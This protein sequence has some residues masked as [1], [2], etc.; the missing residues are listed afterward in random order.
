MCG[1]VAIF[2]PGG[3]VELFDRTLLQKMTDVIAHRGPDAQGHH[4]ERHVALGHRRLS[5]ID[6]KSGQQPLFNE[7]GSVCVVFN[8]EIYNYRELVTEL[9]AL[10]HVFGTR[11]DTEVIVHGWEQWGSDCVSRFR[12]MFAFVVWD[13]N[14]R[15]LFAAR[16]RLGV[17]PLIYAITN[18]RK[19]VIASEIKAIKL[20]PGVDL[21]LDE[22]AVEDFLALSYIPDPKSIFNGIKKLPPA[23]W[24]TWEVG[25]K[26]PVIR[27]YWQVVFEPDHRYNLER[28]SEEFEHLITESVRIRMVSEVPIGAFLSG[29]VDSSIVVDRMS[30]LSNTAVKTCTIGFD[31]KSVDESAHALLVANQYHTEHFQEICT[32]EARNALGDVLTMF[33]EPFADSSALPTY[34]VSSIARKRVTVALS[35]DG[36]DETF[37]GYRRH[38]MHLAEERIRSAIP[39][40]IRS[41]LFGWMGR[42]YPKADWAPQ[43]FRAK[44]T[45]QGLA[46]DSVQ[47]YFES[48]SRIRSDERQELY[49]PGFKSRLNGYTALEVFRGHS[50]SFAGED[51]LS[52][53]QHLDYET[54]LPGDINTKVDRASM[55]NSLEVREPFMDHHLVEWA[56]RLPSQ[57]K[58]HGGQGKYLVKNAFSKR[59]PHSILF[60]PKQGFVVPLKHWM[61]ESL[62]QQLEPALLAS[63]SKLRYFLAPEKIRATLASHRSG[64]TDDASKL[65]SI[66]VLSRF[67][68]ELR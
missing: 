16:D 47:S 40:A 62:G 22:T 61:K 24:M 44:T 49:Q 58:I 1:V 38:R 5:I 17:K 59:L 50:A 12:G 21:S 7:D 30:A 55:A 60:R 29:G 3:R 23:H 45:L 64:R 6:V 68:D 36:A 34:R 19:L 14:R 4:I 41:R 37:G 66:L 2:D 54:Y 56:A 63:D 42:T 65:W 33:D 10:G 48:V 43:V 25:R 28:A 53:I 13:R 18:Q 32:L 20:A 51:P 39:L 27:R 26:E 52:L 67:L 8:G 11:S 31:E 15:T 46:R 57:L 9:E 35:G